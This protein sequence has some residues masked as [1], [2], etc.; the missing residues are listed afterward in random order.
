MQPTLKALPID[1]TENAEPTENTLMN[2][3]QQAAAPMQPTLYTAS[4]D[5]DDCR[6]LSAGHL[7]GPFSH[8]PKSSS[9]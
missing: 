5:A 6:S 2:E 8:T 3:P 4:C 1:P 7:F 9:T